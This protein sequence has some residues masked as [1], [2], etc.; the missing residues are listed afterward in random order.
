MASVFLKMHMDPRGERP[1]SGSNADARSL[2][3]LDA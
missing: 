2:A 1:R 3:K